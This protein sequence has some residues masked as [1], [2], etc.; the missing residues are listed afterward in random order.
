MKRFATS[1][2]PFMIVTVAV[3]ALTWVVWVMMGAPPAGIDDADIFLVYARNF[4]SGNGFIYNIGSERVE[5]FTSLLWVQVLSGLIRLGLRPETWALGLN[6]ILTTWTLLACVR[7]L[8]RR[9]ETATLWPWFLLL[10]ISMPGYFVWTTIALMDTGL[11]STLLTLLI[12]MM[13]EVSATASW[14][15]VGRASILITLLLLTRPESILWAPYLMVVAAVVSIPLCG[16]RRTILTMLPLLA[17]YS[18]VLGALTIFRLYYFGYPLPNTYYANVS[19]SL[20][21]NFTQGVYYCL[22]FLRTNPAALVTLLLLAAS[23]IEGIR[24]HRS[25]GQRTDPVVGRDGILAWCLLP[26]L[27]IP[28]LVGGDHFAASR[29]YQ[30]IWPL[31]ALSTIL[32]WHRIQLAPMGQQ[33]RTRRLRLKSSGPIALVLVAMAAINWTVFP[34]TSGL[35]QEFDLDVNGRFLGGVMMDVFSGLEPL[36]QVG[37]ITAGGFRYSYSGPVLDLLGLNST[38]MAHSP[39]PRFGVKNHAGFNKSV[40]WKWQPDVIMPLQPRAHWE[41]F[42]DS[43]ENRVLKG[44]LFDDDFQGKYVFCVVGRDQQSIRAFFARAFLKRLPHDRYEMEAEIE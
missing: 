3:T 19:P 40:F 16:P 29:F 17:V 11:W 18:G 27:L 4:A 1:L 30:P 37:V 43:F 23:L 36:P 42:R 21:Y 41:T 5:G 2:V 7:Y 35:R 8:Q 10:V 24:W 39:G 15:G 25:S 33:N 22:G 14:A 44:L 6:V 38:E 20:A 26:G 34:A 31:L 28:L 12:L 32:A 9:P 13:L